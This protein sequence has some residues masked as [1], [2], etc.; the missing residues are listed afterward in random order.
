MK[1]FVEL[2]SRPRLINLDDEYNYVVEKVFNKD[3]PAVFSFSDDQ[4]EASKQ[5]RLASFVSFKSLR[6]RNTQLRI[7][8]FLSMLVQTHLIE[9]R[10]LRSFKSNLMMPREYSWHQRTEASSL[11]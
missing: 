7:T 6:F 1:A 2:N 4:S 5:V 9:I 3:K 8:F 10:F 11:D